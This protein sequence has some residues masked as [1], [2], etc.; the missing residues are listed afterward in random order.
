VT[1]QPKARRIVRPPREDDGR[2]PT[3][4]DS[5]RYGWGEDPDDGRRGRD[6]YER[7]R[8]PHHGE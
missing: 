8:P 7:E 4:P 2:L 3:T 6:W 1:D 5:E